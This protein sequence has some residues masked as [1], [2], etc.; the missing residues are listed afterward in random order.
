MVR[1]GTLAVVVSCLAVLA[2]LGGSAAAQSEPPGDSEIDQYAPTLP[3]SEGDKAIGGGGG[4]GNDDSGL[5]PS[6]AAE[7]RAAGADGETALEI[8]DETAGSSGSGRS[9]ENQTADA[10]SGG[11]TAGANDSSDESVPGTIL[12]GLSAGDSGGLGLLLP[13]LLGVVAGVGAFVLLR[14]RSPARG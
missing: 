8:I 11:G 1:I 12:E 2:L 7:L 4:N 6:T 3:D 5:P 9:D 10:G 14:R 13:I